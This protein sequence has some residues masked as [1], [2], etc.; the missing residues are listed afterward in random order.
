M[1]VKDRILIEAGILFGK[2]GIRSMT[3]D[4]LAE[5]LGISKRTIYER[6][7][8]KDTLLMEVI[9]YYK[10]QTQQE[11]FQLIDQSDNAIEALFRI[12]KLTI[13]QMQ[14]MSPAF[15]KDFRKYHQKV[16]LQ[17]SAPGEIRDFSIT[18]RLLETGM[19]Q[20]VFRDDINLE[21][22]NQAIHS[23]FD[24]FGHNSTLVDAGFDRKDMFD[25]I[26][27]PY[28]RGIATKKGRKLL[29]DCKPIL[30]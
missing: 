27:I 25:H 20:E 13:G 12:I 30:E 16:I 17:F 22:V 2:Y 21:I 28:F 19:E 6:F 4:S 9:R 8:D 24:L 1:E 14:R 11:A 23:L 26:L 5:E 7:K 18:K 29:V 3:M 10:D 15:F